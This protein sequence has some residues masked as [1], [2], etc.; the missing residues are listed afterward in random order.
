VKDCHVDDDYMWRVVDLWLR[1]EV[2]Q[3]GGK[4][5]YSLS[6]GHTC[7]I[8]DNEKYKSDKSKSG[9]RLKFNKPEVDVLNKDNYQHWLDIT[10]KAV[11][12][13]LDPSRCRY[14]LDDVVFMKLSKLDKEW[15]KKTNSVWYYEIRR[16][17]RRSW[18]KAVM[19]RILYRGCKHVLKWLDGGV[20]RLAKN[21][22]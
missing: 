15:V 14:F 11:V 20:D 1:Q 10:S 8:S 5:G 18:L 16:W 19:V 2:E 22:M 21:S 13:Y 4:Y 17:E 9:V 7:Y 3:K 6:T 12:K